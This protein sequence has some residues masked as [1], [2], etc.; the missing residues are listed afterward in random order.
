MD[1]SRVNID[2][3]SISCGVR[4]LS[5]MSD[6]AEENLFA[7]ANSFYHP[8]RGQPPAFC[9]W[10]NLDGKEGTLVNGG[11]GTNGH[12]LAKE[13]TSLGFGK[14]IKSDPSINPNT[15]SIIAVWTWIV[16]HEPFKKWYKAQKIEKL[17]DR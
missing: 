13:I 17:K 6:E 12:R 2:H 8:S 7:I 14:V 5:R 9:I 10:S 3:S 4:E 1:H 11:E 15:G 16:D